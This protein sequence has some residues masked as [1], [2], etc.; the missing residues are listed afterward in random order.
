MKKTLEQIL[1]YEK[2]H[3]HEDGIFGINAC[4]ESIESNLEYKQMP[5]DKAL[6]EMLAHYVFQA[7]T[8]VFFNQAMVLA[9]WELINEIN[10]GELKQ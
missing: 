4:K 6:Y 10:Y 8:N 2:A 1:E 3:R 5:R 7:N 9:C